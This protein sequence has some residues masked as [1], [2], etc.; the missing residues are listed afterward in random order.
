[1]TAGMYGSSSSSPEYILPLSEG[2][3]WILVVIGVIF[4]CLSVNG[5]SRALLNDAVVI[6]GAYSLL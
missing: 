3:C 4:D 2:S 5:G 6:V 1:M